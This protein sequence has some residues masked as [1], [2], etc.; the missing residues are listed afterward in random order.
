MNPKT[1]QL[2]SV[3]REVK[4]EIMKTDVF[5]KI[6]GSADQT[7]KLQS[8]LDHVF[9][10]FREFERR[11]SRFRDDSELTEFNRGTGGRVSAELFA[12]LETCER[13]HRETGGIFDPA[14]LPA[15]ER[16]GYS[17][18]SLTELTENVG[19]GLLMLDRTTLTAQKPRGLAIDLGGIGKGAI[20]DQTAAWLRARGYTDFVIDAGGD[21]YAAGVNRE[22]G[23]PYWAFDIE[24]PTNREQSL[25]TILLSDEAVATSGRNRRTW[26][27]DGKR[28]HHLIDPRTGEHAAETLL[29]VSVIAP[30]VTAADIWAKTSFIL[31]EAL[32]LPL[33]EA[34]GLGA[35]L[36]AT[37]GHITASSLWQRK[38]WKE[39]V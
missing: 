19:W 26:I 28:E 31:G 11:F 18:A 13:Y 25:A 20:V 35:L 27:K 14:V 5:V 39:S 17:G 3:E 38:T 6:L 30:S 24:H 2:T 8:D 29:T 36:A 7:K 9:D 33:I 10:L 4:Q 16:I 32:A 23:Y 15:L 22:A 34:Q 12:L 21:I 37:D 1:S